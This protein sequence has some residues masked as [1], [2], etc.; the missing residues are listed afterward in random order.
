[1]TEKEYNSMTIPE[2]NKKLLEEA[3]LE[4]ERLKEFAEEMNSN[5]Q[6]IFETKDI[7]IQM[8]K[9][10][11]HTANKHALKQSDKIQLLHGLIF[12]CA[13][14]IQPFDDGGNDAAKLIIEI[15][16]LTT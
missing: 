15:D 13:D 12:K 14:F 5:Y 4:I 8:L 16:K 10:S 2:L 11:L 9:T 6:K 1:M 7:E 3:L